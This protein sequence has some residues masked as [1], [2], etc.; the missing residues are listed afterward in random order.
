[1]RRPAR[2]TMSTWAGPADPAVNVTT[3][4][5]GSG[6]GWARRRPATGASGVTPV[7]GAGVCTFVVC[8]SK[9][10]AMEGEPTYVTSPP[11]A[12][13]IT[14]NEATRPLRLRKPPSPTRRVHGVEYD[15]GRYSSAAPW[16]IATRNVSATLPVVDT[17]S[18]QSVA[19]APLLPGSPKE[20][21]LGSPSTAPVASTT[22]SRSWS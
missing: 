14:L 19:K 7:T 3:P 5:V 18:T 20:I 4:P 22:A 11:G 2:S 16:G 10:G 15:G 6:L 12:W 17:P 1:M 8:P 9:V 21:V 13:W